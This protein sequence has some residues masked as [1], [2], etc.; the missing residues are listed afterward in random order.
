[1]S[2]LQPGLLGQDGVCLARVHDLEQHVQRATVHTK[3]YRQRRR[4]V[5]VALQLGVFRGAAA[6]SGLMH[7][8]EA[9]RCLV[10][11]DD[12]VCADC[13]RVH[14]PAQLDEEPVRVGLLQGCGAPSS[15]WRAS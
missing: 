3:G 13:V 11:V 7:R 8:E 1:M 14:E 2:A 9:A 5:C 12:A 4:L 6:P 10:D 15:T